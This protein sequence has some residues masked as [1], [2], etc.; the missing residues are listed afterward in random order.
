M[1][2]TTSDAELVKAFKTDGFVA[3]PQFVRGEELTR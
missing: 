3:L 2:T 1:S